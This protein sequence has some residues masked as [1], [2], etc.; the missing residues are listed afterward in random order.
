MSQKGISFRLNFHVTAIA[1]LIIAIVVYINFH[2]SNKILID[3]IEEGA[4]NQCDLVISRISR[5]TIGAEEIAKNASYQVL[6][7]NQHNDLEFFLKQVAS[8]NPVIESLHVEFLGVKNQEFSVCNSVNHCKRKCNRSDDIFSEGAS[9]RQ[10]GV[11]SKP[12]Y[13]DNDSTHLLVTYR[14]P[15]FNPNSEEIVGF[16]YCEISLRK[17]NEMLSKMTIS[18]NGFAFIVNKEGYYLTYPRADWILKKNIFFNSSFIP[19]EKLNFLEHIKSRPNGVYRGISRYFNQQPAWFYFARLA[20]TNWLAIIV[21]PEGE[22]FKEIHLI[23]KKILWVCGLGILILFL[24]NMLI[25]KWILTPLAKVAEAIHEF[26]SIP[27]TEYNTKDEIKILK[28]SLGSWQAQYGSLMKEKAQSE[29]EKLRYEKELKSA[30]E[31]QQNIVPEGKANFLDHPEIDLYATLMPAEKVGGDLYDYFFIDQTHLLIAIGDVSGKGIPASLFMAVAST[32]IKTN[33]KILSS[34]DIVAEVNRE[35]SHR[36]S[37]QYFLTLFVGILD[38]NTGVLDFC[39]AAHNY[40]YILQADRTMKSLSQSHGLPLGIYRDKTYSSSVVELSQNDM[41][42]LY[43][44]GVINAT[45]DKNKYYGTDRLEKNIMNLTDLTAEE[46][47]NKLLGSLLIFKG[48]SPQSD[49]IS[50]L[51]LKYLKKTE[52]QA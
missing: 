46:V 5:I 35:L 41:M 29:Y 24:I 52:S 28:D 16:V 14:H 17:I 22:L 15:V 21:V 18:H 13:C 10:R 12:F 34:K 47:V 44:D 50:I 48:E 30:R 2:Y 7:Y 49:D 8:T 42:I 23:Y 39:N 43:T 27:G 45:D 3:K 38:I 32:L 36:N 1:I 9:T 26:S 6:Y 37:D 31:I 51:V 20:N 25:F 4:I 19:D 11:W 40:P 33:A